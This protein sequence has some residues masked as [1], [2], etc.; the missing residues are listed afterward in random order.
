MEAAIERLQAFIAGHSN[1]QVAK[2][3]L[4]L[5]GLLLNRPTLV[6]PNI[7]DLPRLEDLDLED[8]VPAVQVLKFGGHADAAV[9]Y[10]YRYLRE[11]FGAL[12]A[13]KALIISMMP[14]LF[15]PSVPPTLDV[16][17]PDAAVCYRELPGVELKWVVLEDTAIPRNEFEEIALTSPL[18]SE[19]IGKRVG[20]TVVI[21]KG[22]VQD[23][24]AELVHILPKYVR[25]YQDSMGEMQVRFGAAGAIESVRFGGPDDADLKKGVEII[26]ASVKKRAEALMKVRE[27]YKSGPM[28]LHLFQW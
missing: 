2:L 24:T 19:L 18:A 26:L 6:R 20:D 4:S 28:P 1:H 23:R 5:I 27:A 16:V 15:S 8:V 25:R 13:H 17:G 3:R 12:E 22:S 9:D 10:A 7:E 14:G 21:A 11:N